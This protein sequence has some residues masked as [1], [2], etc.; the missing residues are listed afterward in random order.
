MMYI[1]G[2]GPLYRG[3]AEAQ[4]TS[5]TAPKRCVCS[6]RRKASAHQPNMM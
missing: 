1:V 6:G 5:R 4:R 3:G 2:G